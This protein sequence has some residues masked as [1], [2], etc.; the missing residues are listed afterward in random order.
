MDIILY[1]YNVIYYGSIIILVLALKVFQFHKYIITNRLTQSESLPF[2]ILLY[3][4]T[5]IST[6]I[7]SIIQPPNYIYT[8]P[9]SKDYFLVTN[10]AKVI[11]S[12]FVISKIPT[13][14]VFVA[15]FI[16]IYTLLAS[17]F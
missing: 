5:I 2:Q 8:I 10:N 16:F 1:T 17:Y 12:M 3:H 11:F 15:Q 6:T 7:P 9:N 14:F 13:M 4:Y